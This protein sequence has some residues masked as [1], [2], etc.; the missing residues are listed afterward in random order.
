MDSIHDALL[1]TANGRKIVVEV[2]TRKESIARRRQQV[3]DLIKAGFPGRSDILYHAR[4]V[5]ATGE[6]I[7]NGGPA[8]SELVTALEYATIDRS[9]ALD[10][11]GLLKK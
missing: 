8:Y 10:R 6:L 9:K 2:K 11:L 5:P 1:Q 4:N 3:I 7:L